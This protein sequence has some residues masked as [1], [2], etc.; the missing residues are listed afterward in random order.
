[1]IGKIFPWHLGYPWLW[2]G[3]PGAQL[4]DVIGF[5]G[6]NYLTIAISA[7]IAWSVVQGILRPKAPRKA[8]IAALIA[9]LLISGVNFL[10][11]G[12]DEKWRTPTD[13]IRF[14]IIQ[15]NIGNF[16]KYYVEYQ[17]EYARPITE[18]YLK[19]S[20]EGFAAHPDANVL[21]W[22]ETAFPSS[23]DPGYVDMAN[24]TMT[25]EL[26]SEL[27]LPLMTGAYSYQLRDRRNAVYNSIFYI[28]AD[29]RVPLQPYRKS[30]LLVFG[31]T[32]PF[33][34]Y[35]PYMK[36][37]F[38]DQG[39]FERGRGP[40]VWPLELDG[41]NPKRVSVGLQICYEGLYPWHSAEMAQKGAEVLV[42]VTN[43]SWFGKPFEP[44]QHLY[45]TLARA[46]EFRRPLIRAT[47]TGIST[48]MLASGEILEK[49]PIGAEWT[50]LLKVPFHTQ[51][52]HTFYERNGWL[53]PWILA[54]VWLLVLVFGKR[55]GVGFV[56]GTPT[57]N[58]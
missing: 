45:M 26:V 22:P 53:W 48:A 23:F 28:N 40:V 41:V 10:G 57:R 9:G 15:G 13:E 11:L 5:E 49:S 44:N 20:R 37:F 33:S 56:R 17:S 35:I 2:A 18:K 8:W 58:E 24:Q 21:L 47:N 25:R 39:G 16:E 34:E 12:R 54:I 52:E 6:L 36:W 51:P 29:G 3:W 31:E 30:I 1:V 46:I 4:G 19:L 27:R 43:D 42:N 7:L 14:L 38:P 32:F 50:G 55:L